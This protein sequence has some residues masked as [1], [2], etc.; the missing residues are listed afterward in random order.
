VRWSPFLRDCLAS[1]APVALLVEVLPLAHEPPRQS[2]LQSVVG[3][4]GAGDDR[5]QQLHNGQA[6]GR[7]KRHTTSSI[8]PRWLVKSEARHSAVVDGDKRA[9]SPGGMAA[10][11]WRRRR[12]PLR[13]FLRE[14]GRAC[15]GNW[16]D[17]IGLSCGL[18]GHGLL[19]CMR[20]LLDDHPTFQSSRT[21]LCR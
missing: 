2:Q 11:R 21:S 1:T 19:Y 18:Y 20:A 14:E 9:A 17:D 8:R 15:T 16:A 12:C 6:N 4:L 5:A 3:P 10:A 13:S 7:D